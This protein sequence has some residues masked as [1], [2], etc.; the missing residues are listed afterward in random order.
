PTRRRARRTV[1]SRRSGAWGTARDCTPS[2]R[3]TPAARVSCSTHWPGRVTEMSGYMAAGLLSQL[4][5]LR[6]AGEDGPIVDA[7]PCGRA[8]A[9]AAALERTRFFPRQLVGPDDFTTDQ[10]Y[11]RDKHR[12]HN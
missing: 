3:A 4:G 9:D 6:K 2:R 1:G 7:D 10:R 12:R 11:F 5:N 8:P